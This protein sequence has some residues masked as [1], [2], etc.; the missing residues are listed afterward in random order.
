MHFK[1]AQVDSVDSV[2]ADPPLAWRSVLCSLFLYLSKRQSE[3]VHGMHQ[4]RVKLCS[5]T[6]DHSMIAAMISIID[7]DYPRPTYTNWFGIRTVD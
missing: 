4:T 3:R 1:N 7:Y 6:V 5:A 2:D